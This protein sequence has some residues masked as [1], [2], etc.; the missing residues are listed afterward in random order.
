M[1]E[2]ESGAAVDA[3]AHALG[4]DRGQ[5][6]DLDGIGAARGAY[7]LLITLTRPAVL[8]S[9]PLRQRTLAPG[10]YL[11]AG[12]A[13]GP[14][15]IGARVRRHMKRGKRR[16]WHVDDLT[17]VAEDLRPLVFPDGNECDLVQSLVAGGTFSVA[18]PGF[19]SSDCRR[20]DGHLLSMPPA[21]A[22]SPV[23]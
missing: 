16:H 12:S 4:A 18:I 13:N 15:G 8:K 10:R 1:T 14:G 22:R 9:R 3:I 6:T 7:L 11:Y 21:P 5:V 2:E 23:V 19:G 17:A 20:C